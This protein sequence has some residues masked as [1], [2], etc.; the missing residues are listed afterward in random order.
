MGGFN[1]LLPDPSLTLR[2]SQ[3]VPNV[4]GFLQHTLVQDILVAVHG[5]LRSFFLFL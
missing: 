5:E 4:F 1:A 3:V 2:A